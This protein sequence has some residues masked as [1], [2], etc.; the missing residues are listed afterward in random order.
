MEKSKR[1]RILLVEASFTPQE[2]GLSKDSR[3]RKC[4][5]KGKFFHILVQFLSEAESRG[6][7][8]FPG[9]WAIRINVKFKYA[10]PFTIRAKRFAIFFCSFCFLITLFCI[11][12]V[13][14]LFVIL[15]S[16][17]VYITFMI[18]KF[19][20][21]TCRMSIAIYCHRLP[22]AIQ[23]DER[24]GTDMADFLVGFRLTCITFATVRHT[25]RTMRIV[26]IPTVSQIFTMSFAVLI[27]SNPLIHG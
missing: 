20:G 2:A 12:V 16:R 15:N 23:F 24:L 13:F 4:E 25:R 14:R 5:Y 11:Y 18:D 26:M 27:R 1:I 7:N 17:L 10:E 22:H 6:T 8:P 9:T 21:V 3:L 19:T